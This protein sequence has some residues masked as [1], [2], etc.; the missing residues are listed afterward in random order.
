M[1]EQMGC[2]VDKGHLCGQRAPHTRVNKRGGG[3]NVRIAHHVPN[4][5][6]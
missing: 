6:R 3:V 1:S 5:S 4:K 2:S